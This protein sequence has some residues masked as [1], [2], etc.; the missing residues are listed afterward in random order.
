M[1]NVAVL[2]SHLLF[3]INAVIQKHIFKVIQQ[4]SLYCASTVKILVE[5]GLSNIKTRHSSVA[6][7]LEQPMEVFRRLNNA[8]WGLSP[9]SGN[10][11][12]W[13]H[14]PRGVRSP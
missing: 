11:V 12:R 13:N 5:S 6:L 7:M 10:V 4:L 14:H 8:P 9:L 3:Q 1:F 2:H